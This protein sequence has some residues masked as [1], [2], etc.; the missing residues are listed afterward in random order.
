MPLSTQEEV[1]AE[2]Y[3]EEE[4]EAPRALADA[5]EEPPRLTAEE[6]KSGE[7]RELEEPEEEPKR[8]AAEENADESYP[9]EDEPMPLSTQEE[10]AAER[11]PEEEE[12]APRALA[13]ADEEPPRLTAEEHKSGED[14]REID[15]PEEEP[16]R[17][18]VA[19]EG[20]E[21][22]R[23]REVEES[24][25]LAESED[26]EEPMITTHHVCV[27]E[28][29]KWDTV[30]ESVPEDL[31][32]AFV[33]D[34][35]DGCGVWKDAVNNVDFKIGSLHASVDVTHRAAVA[36][37]EIKGRLDRYSFPNVWKLYPGDREVAVPAAVPE[38]ADGYP[39]EEEPKRL[40]AEEEVVAPLA[41]ADEEPPRLSAEE[42]KSGEDWREIDEPEDEPPRALAAEEDGV[43]KE[44]AAARKVTNFMRGTA[45][46]KQKDKRA[47]AVD[48]YL[49][50]MQAN[51]VAPLASEEKGGDAAAWR[52]IDEPEEEVPR[53]LAAEEEETAERYPEEDE[54][55]PLSTQEE[56][57]AERYPEEEEEAPRALADAD[58][59]PPRLTAE[60][61]KSG[62]D[63]REID[64]PEEE[65]TRAVVATEGLENDRWREVEESQELAESEDEEEPMI[66][67]HHVCVFEGDKWDT[68]LESVPEDLHT[69]FVADVCDGC[70]VW[71]DAVNNVDFKIGSLHASVDVTHRA[72]VA[73]EEIKGRLDRY[74][75][76]NVWKLYPG[77]REV[78]VPA[79]VPEA[80]DGYPE[81]EEPKRLSAEEEVVAPLADADE[82][83]PRLSAEEHKSG[84]D[85]REIDEPEDEPPRALAAEEDG[86]DKEDAAARK[87]TNFMRG[88]AAKKQKDKRAT[89][90]DAYL[91]DMQANDVAPLASE[92]KGGDAGAWR[93]I[94]EPEEEVPR[95]LAAEEE[96][97]AERY[98]EEEEPKRLVAEEENADESYPEEDEP[99][100]LSTQEEVAA[101][102][103]PE[104]EEEV[105]RTLVSEEEVAA[106]LADADEEPPR[107]SAEEHK[108]G[109]DWREIDEPEDEPPRALAAEEDGVDKEDAAARKVTNFMRGTAAKKQKD[110]RA[111]AVDAYLRDMQAND[112]APLASEEKGG[113]AGAWREIDE[114]E[115]E[116]PRALAAEEEE[117]AERYPEEDEP[118]RLVVEEENADESYPEEDEPMPLSTQEEVAA[119][120]YPEEEEEAPRALADADEE[121]PRLTAEEHKSGEDWREID[122]PEEEPTR[123]VVATEGLENDRWREVE[124][125]QELAESE[126]EE[127]PM[128]TT[129]HVCVFEGDK[130]DTV[131]ESVPEDLHTAFVADVC[132]GCGVWKDA[133]NNVD[134]KIGSLHASVDVT[135]RAAVAPEEI[136][137]RL[138]RYSFP[139]V[140]KLYPGD[141]E[142][143]VPAAVPEAADGYPEEEEP[144]RLSAEEEVVAPL[145][146]ADE[147]PPRLS[148]EEHKSGE[149]WREIDEPEDEPPRAL[150]AEEDGVDKEDAAARKVTN[151]MRGTAAKKQKDKRATAVDAYL[152]DMQ[153]N[154]VA[155]LASEEK[156]GDAGAWRE[157]DEPEEEVPRALA[158]E[159]EETAERYPEEE[160]PKR[161][162]A[163]EENA[164]E[165]YPEEDEPNA[166]IHPRGGGC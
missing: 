147:E 60:E 144:K 133:V 112:V 25:E 113:D 3:P 126:D 99:K 2:R 142:V 114:P 128:I 40:S 24:Q 66:T 149:D 164:D 93:E 150:A 49:R 44:D 71:K 23:W 11:Y 77:D 148:A 85:W 107:L 79:A 104:E 159:E 90:V 139:N 59:E 109:E 75:F 61:H 6:H 162:V 166:A 29:D 86:V 36:P 163:E 146:D 55:M 145:A 4:E 118:K 70:G 105:P 96:E 50:D 12:E 82:E 141:R 151:F 111:T 115:E 88:T 26:E 8:L 103:Y 160:E 43:D 152:R 132:D 19:T 143:A 64:E 153:A 16:T 125:S 17:A 92:E 157:I 52:E 130:W 119:E 138:D 54:P 154:D 121:P 35:C 38:A 7:W 89:A 155:P 46:K 97:T 98:P 18:V 57:A 31:H 30:L 42:H 100:P 13:D 124:E 165:S 83:P 91:R 33:A 53:A 39:E 1:A 78:A 117:T 45:A 21:N 67:T 28:G 106:P 123:A 131:L 9:E 41:D 58:E 135:H 156:G 95:A 102:R 51:D 140:W 5:D 27:F 56:V 48:A 161:L 65:P 87:V 22:D 76:P 101:E 32:T 158:A 20:L 34:V 73:P 122:E 116:V 81:E 137:G 110:K 47:T 136:K 69:A 10:V 72:A 94:D 80:A 37:E 14:W 134:F 127:E 108:S 74:S 15:E 62:E 68:V 129:H 63:W 120:R 84:E